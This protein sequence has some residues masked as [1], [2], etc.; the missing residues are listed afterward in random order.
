MKLV[1]AIVLLLSAGQVEMSLAP[2]QPIPHVYTDDPVILE[3]KAA[4]DVELGVRIGV[5]GESRAI[6]NLGRMGLRAGAPRWVAVHGLPEERGLFDVLVTL[7]L[8]GRI[9]EQRLAFCRIDRPIPVVEAPAGVNLLSA[10]RMTV[11]AM[12]SVPVRQVRLSAGLENA[13]AVCRGAREAGFELAIAFDV[14]QANNIEEAAE[15][16]AKA[17]GESAARW[18]LETR[19]S[20]DRVAA[21]V[22]GLR[23]GGSRA[24]TALVAEGPDQLSRL[25]AIGMGQHVS[26]LVF[27]CDAPRRG[28]LTAFR[29]AAEQA[30]YEGLP[31]IVVGRGSAPSRGETG[32]RT[33]QQ[34]V[35]NCADG[36]AITHLDS[37]A[38][39]DRGVFQPSYVPLSAVMHNLASTTYVGELSMP[40]PAAGHVFAKGDWWTLVA[41]T[42]AEARDISLALGGAT[43]LILKDL[44][45]NTLSAPAVGVGGAVS[46][47]VERAPRYLSGRGGNVIAQAA[48]NAA[49]KEARAL[50]ENTAFCERAS[51]EFITTVKKFAE[52]GRT[53]SERADF[54]ALL[55]MFPAI[56][57]QWHRGV[58]PKAAAVPAIASLARLMRRLCIAEEEGGEPFFE[59]LQETLNR[60]SGFQ[61]DYLTV[62]GGAAGARERGDWLLGEVTR[63]MGEAGILMKEGRPVEA[64]AVAALAEWRARSLKY[65]AQA[66][67]LSQPERMQIAAVAKDTQEKRAAEDE[68]PGAKSAQP[69]PVKPA[70]A[71]GE[72][73][74]VVQKNDNPWVIAKQY[75]VKRADLYKWNNWE[76]D[77]MLRI[78]DKVVIRITTD[79]ATAAE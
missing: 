43:D 23:K 76:K 5:E 58:L 35:M 19:Q 60:S 71:P 49:A 75:K 51:A 48:R 18:D 37:S 46:L 38:L 57:E 44:R 67:P 12:R 66:A 25:L 52:P 69:E 72:I 63:L 65:A 54:L 78:G 24:P 29:T 32:D 11:L 20:A 26:A 34:I 50:L 17:I 9:T 31:L 22:R 4:E 59:P 47:R 79:R 36:A 7:D 28:E 77:P 3:L 42:T 55:P 39:F 8:A 6:I 68:P 13:A 62:S 53:R 2:D 15:T 40:S 10:D 1:L 73:I 21:A 74:H 14:E 45:N 64:N 61:T 56:E 16:V 27:R 70:P 33:V 41:W 30:G